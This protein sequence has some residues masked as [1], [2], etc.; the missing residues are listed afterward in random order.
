M[1][2]IKKM[3]RKVIINYCKSYGYKYHFDELEDVDNTN[4]ENTEFIFKLSLVN[5]RKRRNTQKKIGFN[6]EGNNPANKKV[7]RP[8]SILRHNRNEILGL[9]SNKSFFSGYNSFRTDNLT[10][11]KKISETPKNNIHNNLMALTQSRPNT[12]VNKNASFF[13]SRNHFSSLG[14]DETLKPKMKQIN[15][16]SN[17]I[18][19]NIIINDVNMNND[20]KKTLLTNEENKKKFKKFRKHYQCWKGKYK[21]IK[22][23]AKCSFQN[24]RNFKSS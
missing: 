10:L 11:S 20:S 7:R 12:N 2:S 6:L 23:Y 4:H 18:N 9:N 3:T 19:Y 24:K 5:S 13:S 15:H 14:S 22:F 21:K 8:R 1:K 17:N 16:I